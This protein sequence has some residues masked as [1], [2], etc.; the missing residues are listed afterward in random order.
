MPALMPGAAPMTGHQPSPT[1][2]LF[3]RACF[4]ACSW[5]W[6]I[7]MWF[8]TLMVR[9]FGWPGWLAFLLPNCIG[10][11][12]V[13]VLSTTASSQNL[14]RDHA[15]ALRW[16]SLVTIWFHAMWLASVLPSFATELP[17]PLAAPGGVVVAAL[18]VLGAIASGAMLRH[19][20][21][22][23][24]ALYVLSIGSMIGAALTGP[25]LRVPDHDPLF[26]PTELLWT[27]PMLMLGFGCSPWLD[28]TF[29]RIRQHEPGARGAR[30]FVLC[31]ALLFPLLM[32]YT[33]L[34]AG[35]LQRGDWSY[36]LLLHLIP[37]AAFTIS[38][39]TRE[40]APGGTLA[41]DERGL[42]TWPRTRWWLITGAVLM[43][44]A[45]WLRLL[46]D[47]QG[48]SPTELAYK[49]FLGFYG[50]IFP[51]YVWIVMLPR[52]L[53]RRVCTRT[54]ALAIAIAA[55]MFWTGYIGRSFFWLVPAVG[56]VLLAPLVARALH[57]ARAPSPAAP[58]D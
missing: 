36:Y 51:A 46:G 32:V 23:A 33:L 11:M 34:Y 16:F 13:G 4:L 30:P 9:D 18:A 50:L 53:P 5:C 21:W 7:G 17:L 10:A 1:T 8:P 56:V 44:G 38:V 28:A 54:C 48:T 52:G 45:F 37:Q 15:P 42:C 35:G 40:L 43:L 58:R 14:V 19:R 26:P 3:L 49:L 24:G 20:P 29:H 55:P 12:L 57:K 2:S 41:P 27:L 22:V 39:H 31:F 47:F 6:C 25:T